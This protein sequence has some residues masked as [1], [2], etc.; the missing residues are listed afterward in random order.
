M[1]RLAGVLCAGLCF[2][3]PVRGQ[4]IP[5]GWRGFAANAQ[6]TA[7]APAASQ[8]LARIHWTMP[9]DLA[10][11]L[12]P[13]GGELLIHYASPMITPKNT[14]LVPVKTTSQGSFEIAA[15][16][17]TNGANIWTLTTDYIF[18]PYDWAPPL[19]AHLTG[20]NR[21]YIAGAGGTVYFRDTPDTATGTTGQQAFYGIA[22]YQ[23]N[24]QTYQQNVVIDTPITAD[25]RG[26][27]YF[28]FVVLGSTPLGLKSG[29]ARMDPNGNGTWISA[30]DAAGD[31]SMTQVAMNC[32]PAISPDGSTIYIAVSN[33]GQ[34]YLV[35][36]DST[37]L[38]PKYKALLLDPVT[39]QDASIY[40]ESSASPTI[41]PDG[42]VYYGVL[43]SSIGDHNCRG[44]LLNF[45]ADLSKE[46]APDS[47]GWDDTV[48]IVSPPPPIVSPSYFLMSK[49]NNYYDC[50]GGNGH[51]MIAILDPKATQKDAYSNATVMREVETKLGPNHVPGEPPGA[52]YEWCIN[53]AV[54]DPF[55]KSVI[56]N[57]EDGHTYRWYLPAN[58]LTEALLLNDP[59]AEAYTPTIIGPD[60]TVYA[61][62]NA[63]LYAIGN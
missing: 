10:P 61:I 35:G 9:V 15:V 13:G 22:N 24:E 55:S 11:P 20:Q 18:P 40:D 50:G 51:N 52:V 7:T 53:S 6:H 32:A 42:E 14:V 60:G 31:Q 21:L 62:N 44:W 59:I 19:P 26:Y 43:E 1:K 45:T 5:P 23:A 46:N 39:G 28:G 49:Y 29:I 56:A 2:A 30:G 54:F 8:S 57:S 34:G 58:M 36:L 41:G 48:S 33:G 3:A 37:T 63:T 12:R 4:E 38:K 25:N 16:A 17:G 47:F 27:I